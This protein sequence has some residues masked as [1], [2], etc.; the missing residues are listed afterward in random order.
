MTSI[1]QLF[2]ELERHIKREEHDKVLVVS[3]KI[4][5]IDPKDK[6]AL[7]CKAIT[8]IRLERYTDALTILNRQLDTSKFTFEKAYCL[9]RTNQLADGAQLI[10]NKRKELPSSSQLS[11][12][13]RHLE[14]QMLYRME[15]Y[16]DCIELYASMLQD[17]AVADDS[18][19]DI[20]TNYKACK[21]AVL[22]SGQSL[23]SKWMSLDE[24]T[25]SKTTA[26]TSQTYELS[27]NAA[28]AKIAQGEY[29]Q[30]LKLLEESKRVCREALKDYDEEEIEQELAIIVVQI[31]YV[32]QLMGKTEQAKELY[33]T[34]L[35]SKALEVTVPAVA[36]NNLV[37][38]QKDSDLFDSA[39]KIK[40]ATTKALGVKFFSTQKR[41]IAMNELLLS[42]YQN[43]FVACRD[44]A[45]QQLKSHPPSEYTDALYLILAAVQYK[46]QKKASKALEELREFAKERPQS[47]AI[48]FAIIQLQL[49]E[50]NG[51]N[52]KA[53]IES[54]S[55]FLK[56]LPEK[57][58]YRPGFVALLVWLYDQAGQ[59]DK[60]M[61]LLS[62]ASVI[63]AK[64]NNT[65]SSG[66][67]KQEAAGTA[68]PLTLLKQTA[69]FKLRSHRYK[70]A[71]KDYEE[72]VRTD[73][74]D[75]TSIA[76]LIMAYSEIEPSL[77]EKYGTS[78]PEMD[79]SMMQSL[80]VE[81]LE[82][83]V[84]G[85]RKEYISSTD[86]IK[87][88]VGG[89]RRPGSRLRRTGA[90]KAHKRKP[91]LPKNLDPTQLGKNIDPERWL[92][93][94]DRAAARLA[95]TRKTGAG[96]KKEMGKGPQGMNMEGGGIGGTGS[97]RI[98][99]REHLTTSAKAV[100]VEDIS[101]T[102]IDEAVES[103]TSSKAKSGGGSSNASKKKKGKGKGKW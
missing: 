77:A 84:P 41:T 75:P 57:E 18:Y 37:V 26:P 7:H 102:K 94:R 67:K 45:K 62:E 13:L 28:C 15:R 44:S 100:A 39:K 73:P 9:Y 97:A 31:A 60:G 91:L 93:K 83:V 40:T 56:T 79:R 32:Y 43:K 89:R 61:D 1:Q 70:D 52:F 82:K 29:S 96:S 69:A 34:V 92:P 23:D 36:A 33:Q 21:A 86:A 38:L 90:R 71:A 30:A 63:W 48:Q 27:F 74:S 12:D 6:D 103:P 3:D 88:A 50:E 19:N 58:Q 99:G 72:L 10:A 11:W 98:A 95:R 68:M 54:L 87:A 24:S 22:Y 17:T 78:L 66:S 42:L 2:G 80:D 76:G 101:I 25:N 20:L 59:G 35:K 53:A 4:L 55:N 14:A 65:S 64:S 51:R 8:L 49:T 81:T 47:V 46:Q 5:K 85:H 16:Q